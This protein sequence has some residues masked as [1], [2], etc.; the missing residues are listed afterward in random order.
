M[1]NQVCRTYVVVCRAL[2]HPWWLRV[3]NGW[4]V[5]TQVS[6]V[7]MNVKVNNT[8]RDERRMG[9][10]LTVSAP[11]I[12]LITETFDMRGGGLTLIRMAQS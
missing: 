3:E 1:G 12:L 9:D 7:R 8:A 6:Q 4:K 10:W 11:E 5:N 2:H